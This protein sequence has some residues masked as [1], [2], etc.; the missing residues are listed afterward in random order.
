M[1]LLPAEQ[2]TLSSQP[3]LHCGARAVVLSHVFAGM[4]LITLNPLPFLNTTTFLILSR[5]EFS[6]AFTADER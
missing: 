1:T 6:S 4:W 5:F 3:S 2:L